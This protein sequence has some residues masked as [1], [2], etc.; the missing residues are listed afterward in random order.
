MANKV[1][2]ISQFF[3]HTDRGNIIFIVG[4]AFAYCILWSVTVGD[5]FIVDDD[6]VTYFYAGNVY[7]NGDIDFLRTPIYPLICYA[8]YQI[9]GNN[10]FESLAVLNLAFFL[11]SI[12]YFFRTIALF[13]Q[14]RVIRFVATVLYAWNI[15]MAEMSLYIMTES[16]SVSGIVYLLYLLSIILVGKAS[17]STLWKTSA[18][19]LYLI[20]LRPFNVCLIPLVGLVIAFAYIKGRVEQIRPSIAAFSPTAIILFSYC[21]WFKSVY[22]FFGFSYVSTINVFHVTY[23]T[24]LD[25]LYNYHRFSF[26]KIGKTN[27]FLWIWFDRD[28]S[29]TR[30]AKVLRENPYEFI[31]NKI[32][33]AAK[34]CNYNFPCVVTRP[35]VY[36][37]L[38]LQGLNFGT[39]FIIIIFLSLF[40]F[41]LWLTKRH[42][43]TKII[44]FHLLICLICIFASIFGS[45]DSAIDR[46]AMPMF[47]SLCLLMGL[48]A[49][50]TNLRLKRNSKSQ[51]NIAST[52]PKKY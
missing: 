47:P 40:E 27:C 20:L 52:S 18:T 36:F 1:K 29:K 42:Y 38:P 13:S 16:L 28:N 30:L 35:A 15:S 17:K 50:Q 12:V 3:F 21:M 4:V 34:S 10:V 11:I 49:E 37:L 44:A 45:A 26:E 2:Q 51:N 31:Q 32:V 6:T 22:G 7:M 24:H 5:F 41:Y 14:R 39:I 8:F 43:C 23:I 48:F 46:L 9:F 33:F 25:E 19:L